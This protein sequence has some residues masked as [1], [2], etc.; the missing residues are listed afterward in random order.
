MGWF[1]ERGPYSVGRV[2]FRCVF[3]Y[4]GHRLIIS[5]ALNP[6]KKWQKLTL[7]PDRG[8]TIKFNAIHKIVCDVAE[9]K[10]LQDKAKEDGGNRRAGQMCFFPG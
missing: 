3:M 7:L 5:T 10:Q 8:G 6:K 2:S 9:E 4:W 1:L